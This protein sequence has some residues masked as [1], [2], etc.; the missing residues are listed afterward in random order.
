MKKNTN[1][2][3]ILNIES[4]RYDLIYHVIMWQLSYKRK[5][6]SHVKEKS[7]VKKSTRKIYKQKGTGKARHGSLKANLM[8]GGGIAFGPNKKKKYIYRI[9]KKVKKHAI[10]NAVALKYKERSILI[11]EKTSSN[12]YKVA[13]F[14]QKYGN[15]FKL[16]NKIIFVDHKMDLCLLKSIKNNFKLNAVQLN[17]INV[18]DIIINK[19]ICFS[20]KSFIKLLS[21]FV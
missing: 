20:R 12:S 10:F 4:I 8:R 9:N 3:D 6:L 21:N 16:N 2:I 14:Y 11:Y 17:G 1:I 5:T 18:L 7:D 13:M 19:L 15:F